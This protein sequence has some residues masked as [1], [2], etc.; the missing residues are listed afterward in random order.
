M[1]KPRHEC[2]TQAKPPAPPLLFNG[3][4]GKVGRALSLPEAFQQAPSRCLARY[5]VTWP[6][7]V[8]AAGLPQNMNVPRMEEVTMSVAPSLFKS[9]AKIADPTPERL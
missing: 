9:P 6:R 2:R 7:T 4:R 5:R 8:F 1:K 3:L